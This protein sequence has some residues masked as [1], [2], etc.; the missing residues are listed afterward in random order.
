M[1]GPKAV[2][3]ELSESERQ[4]V[5]R[6]VKAHKTDQQMAQRG[7]IILEA[8]AGRANAE[9]ARGQGVSLTMVRLWRQRWLDL[10][11]LPLRE[12]SVAERL[13]DLPRAG[14]PPRISADQMCQIIALACEAPEQ[15][16]RPISHWS[17]RE[18]ADE[19]MR[20]KIIETISPRHVR[21]LLKRRCSQA[22]SDSLLVNA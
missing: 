21:R 17:G 11:P 5:E 6:L 4:E 12:V 13:E 9:I 14:A 1:P 22:S 7:R 8:S 3:I 19:V 18:I 16:G 15:A 2:M 10:Q 20:R